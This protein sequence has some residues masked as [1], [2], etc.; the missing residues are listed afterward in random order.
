MATKVRLLATLIVF[1]SIFSFAASKSTK[2]NITWWCNQTPHPSTCKYFMSH[3]RHHFSLKHRSKFRL[4]SVQLALEKALIAQRQV[5][6]LGQN[7][8]H[9]HQRAVWADCLKLHS[10]TI[11]QLNRTLIG[12]GKKRL[13]CTDVDAQTW[14]STALTNIQT[15][16]T[17]S[18]DLNVSDFTM[19]AMSK[20]LSELI[21]NT[22]A[23]NGV[24]LEDN[25]T[26]EFPSWFSRHS[27]RLLQSASITAMAT[28][29]VAKDGSGRFRS[30][31]AAINAASKRRYKTRLIIH[32]KRGVYRENI[33]VGVNNNNIWLVGDGVRNTIIT[34]SRSVGGGYTTYSSA[35]AGIDGLRFVARGITFSNT[36]GPR[37]GQA[38]ALRSASD[39]SVFYRCSF[40]GY[41][42]TLFVH[43]QR[44]FY[45][46]CYIYGTID[47][48]FGNAA[49]VFQNSIILV[50]RPL[51][52]QA[53]MITAQGR[54]D[55]FQNTGI[56]IHNSQILPAPDLKPVA[57]VF[58]TY[59][60][61]PWMRYSR[62]VIL[63]TYID[64][65]IN[66][67]GWSPWL[68]SDFAQDTL[69]YGE[70]KNFGPGSSTRRRVAWKGFH[71]ITSP[72]VASG[73]P[74]MATKLCL[75][76]LFMC[77]CSL[78]S[79]SIASND[80]IDY[81]CSKTPNPEPCKYFM[82]QNP[83][84][85]LPKQRSDFRKMAIELA[86]QRA[87]NAQNHNK[88]LGPKCRNEKEKAAWADCLKLYEDTIAELNHTIDSNTKCT[89]FDAQTWLSTALTNLETCKA[90]FK[91]LG[92]SDFVLPLMSNNVSKLIRN[93]LALKGNASSTLPQT[94]NDGFPSWVKTGDRKLLQTSSPSPN[95]VVAQDG[96][97]NHRTIKAA[98]DAAAKRSG[99]RRFVIRIK[100]GVYRE[101]LD[102]GKK[103]KNIMLVG[104]G[105]RNTIITGSRSVGGGFTTF[106]SATVAVTGEGFIARG[107]T[108]RNTAGPQN[109]QAVAL[110]SGSDL[111]VF[112]R[113]GFEGYQDTLYVHSQRQFYKE[114][115]IYGT[116]DFIFGN[117][118]VR[119]LR[120]TSLNR[121][122]I[123]CPHCFREINHELDVSRPRLIADLSGLEPSPGARLLDSLA[124]MLDPPTRLQDADF[125]RTIRWVPGSANGPWITLQF[126]DPPSRRRPAI[127]APQ[128]V[129]P[130]SNT[131]N[132]RSHIDNFGNDEDDLLSQD[133][134]HTEL[135]G[136]PPAPVS[137][138]EALPVVKITEQH[139][140]NDMHCPVCKEIF[141]VGGDVMEL[142]C[143]HLYHSDCIVRWLNLHNTCPVCRYE[144]CDESD[145]DLPGENAEFFDFE[146]LT[147]SINWLRNQ[148]HSL[149]PIRAFSDWAQ[150]C[151]DFL[152]SRVHTTSRGGNNIYFIDKVLRSLFLHLS[153]CSIRLCPLLQLN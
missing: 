82:K 135:L 131:D 79:S 110:R 81:W 58:E 31:Q 15:C 126:V 17:G 127:A 124:Q 146:E 65:F 27:R 85:F 62:T 147:N 152:D 26:Q 29:V 39:L 1:S 84:H 75:S 77:L 22:L 37:K 32:V 14:L 137:A 125:G 63:Q 74:K 71:V 53:N 76:L 12:I 141:E 70:Y 132:N 80:Q 69:Y 89:E 112:Y 102:I 28:L 41:Q 107:I 100:S 34:S 94:Y 72:S 93:T 19:P 5:S 86:V 98:L 64:G 50:R 113:C 45:R 128:P 13:R 114:C 150:R 87:L 142:P 51:K 55:P 7:C 148:L 103:L 88:W 57:G 117:A 2:S 136:P 66:P 46:E 67:A 23:I 139:L 134:T 115:Y 59:L 49:V 120:F 54:N 68:N 61:R 95:L 4:M 60:G 106:N 96:S 44:Q 109:H 105:L 48:I 6:R 42:D 123:F 73:L 8:E 9:Q 11:L 30:I 47:F 143:K 56:S 119:T 111:S 145:K 90:G 18:L 138:I 78:L 92:V 40:Q 91:D 118:A 3:S 99:S 104:D 153:L 35:T 108:F 16:R 121:L 129:V 133:T 24:L 38:V 20:N 122:E 151:L 25:S 140:M 33:E 43:S 83:K 144:L 97:G 10:N 101:N 52:G 36:A 130:P 116:V 21:S 149:Q